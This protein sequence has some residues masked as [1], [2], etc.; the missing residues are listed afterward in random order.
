MEI[1]SLLPPPNSKKRNS[2]VYEEKK[3][4]ASRLMPDGTWIVNESEE[5][6]EGRNVVHK[7]LQLRGKNSKAKQSQPGT[8]EIAAQGLGAPWLIHEERL[9]GLWKDSAVKCRFL[10][11][12]YKG[13]LREEWL[14]G[15]PG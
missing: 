12:L 15:E 7:R 6:K 11:T 13:I 5:K 1:H 9:R 3:L 14:A 10:D 8:E 4:P 2:G